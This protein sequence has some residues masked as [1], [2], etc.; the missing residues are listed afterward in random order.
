MDFKGLG[1]T[2]GQETQADILTV[3]K[4]AL[5]M[6]SISSSGSNWFCQGGLYH[7]VV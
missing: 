3:T 2:D 1:S 5:S 4:E 7:W 6:H